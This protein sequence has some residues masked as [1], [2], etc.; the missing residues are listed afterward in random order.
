MKICVLAE[1]ESY[2]SEA[3]KLADQLDYVFLN[4]TFVGD[5]WK[6]EVKRL[7]KQLSEYQAV[8]LVQEKGLALVPLEQNM[9]PI[10]IDF[11]SES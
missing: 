2:F 1:G 11:T 7:S 9:S 10:Y 3:E 6:K 5:L 8:L 4:Q